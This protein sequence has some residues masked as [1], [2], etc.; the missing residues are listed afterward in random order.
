MV[1]VAQKEGGRWEGSMG[2]NLEDLAVRAWGKKEA[3]CEDSPQI[4]V[5][6]V[7]ATSG[8]FFF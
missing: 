5:L 6:W 3:F 8:L 4:P 2:Q 7:D 1:A